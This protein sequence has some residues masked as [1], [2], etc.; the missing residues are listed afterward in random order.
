VIGTPGWLIHRYD[1]VTST[2]DVARVLAQFGAR[3]RT[4][5]LS[6]EQTAG[7]GRGGRS[8]RSPAG[9]AVFCTIILRPPI[10]SERLSTLPLLSGVAVAE[11][12]E[13]V[14]GCD[15]RL[16]WP[17]DVWLGADQNNAKVAG[18]LVTS[19]L[20]GNAVD[21]VLVGIG[22][23][24][25]VESDD[26]PQG[27]TSIH[28]ATGAAATPDEVFNALLHRFD[29][30]YVDFVRT[31]GRPSLAGWRARAALLS[32]VVTVEDGSRSLTGIFSG[33]DEDGGLLIEEPGHRIQKVVAGDLVRG[34]RSFGGV[35]R[36]SP[37]LR[38]DPES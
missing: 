2:M 33:I 29:R 3:D 10:T 5:V 18:V 9:T 13:D 37:R 14:S 20:H 28:A 7:R 1:T 24:V 22:I 27:A 21:F 34:P 38:G 30:A 36:S 32:E 12:I 23:N 25:L 16:K 35:D 26:L 11:A 31:H 4:V 15:A 8:W 19:S 6:V 17:N